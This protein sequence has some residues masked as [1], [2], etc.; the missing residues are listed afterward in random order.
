MLEICAKT[1]ITSQTIWGIVILFLLLGVAF[2]AV[3]LIRRF[4]STN[5]ENSQMLPTFT[6]ESLKEM[7]DNG[8]ITEDE[9]KHLRDKIIKQT[10]F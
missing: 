10:S 9:Y 8:Q 5:R 2:E 4:F 3:V 7:Y 6:L 1:D